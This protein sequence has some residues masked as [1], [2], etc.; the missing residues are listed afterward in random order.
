MKTSKR[1][2]FFHWAAASTLV[3]VATTALADRA[4]SPVDPPQPSE[5]VR[6]RDLDLTAPAD[7]QVLY[8]RIRLAAKRVCAQVNDH[9]WHAWK[10]LHERQCI[11]TSIDNAVRSANNEQLTALRRGIR[12]AGL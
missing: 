1:S 4:P 9:W 12:L 7:V 3:A 8:Y 5:A 2:W 10:G 6:F 11:D